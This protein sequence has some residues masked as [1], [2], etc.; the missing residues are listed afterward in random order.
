MKNKIYKGS[1]FVAGLLAILL[2]F[3]LYTEGNAQS[4]RGLVNDGVELY[5]QKKYS[6]SEANFKKGAEKAPNNFNSYFNLGDAQ[7]K[8]GRYDEAA[9]SYQQ[10]LLKTQDKL[11]KAS[12]YHNIG[13]SLLKSQKVEES[14]GAYKKA[15]KLNPNDAQ[16]KYNLSYAL[17]LLKQ[18]QNNKNNKN[19]KQN[20]DNKQNQNKNDQNKNDQNKNDQNNRKQNESQ[21]RNKMSKEEAERILNALKN[22]EQDLQKKLRKHEGRPVKTDKDW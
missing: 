3:A 18:Q 22:N 20:K 11:Q 15:L 1:A 2:V 6:D 9:K 14:I 16:T 17:N 21:D 12:T 10:A 4:L 8:Q 13:N 19:N 7:Y 5:K